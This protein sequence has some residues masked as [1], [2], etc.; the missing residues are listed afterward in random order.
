VRVTVATE[1]AQLTAADAGAA[2][3]SMNSNMEKSTTEADATLRFH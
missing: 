3:N 2:R 1:R